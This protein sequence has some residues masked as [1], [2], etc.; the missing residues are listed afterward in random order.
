M[1]D[2]RVE[3]RIVR[4]AH[5]GK[6]SDAFSNYRDWRAFLGAVEAP[7]AC[8]SVAAALEAGHD[9]LTGRGWMANR[10]SETRS[11]LLAELRVP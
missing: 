6:N 4:R 3:R 7:A 5:E 10:G 2:A 9:W 11:W 1:S 8:S